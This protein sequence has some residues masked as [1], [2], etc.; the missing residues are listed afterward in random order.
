[1]ECDNKKCDNYI[2]GKNFFFR[3]AINSIVM[4]VNLCKSCYKEA[5]KNI[6]NVPNILPSNYIHA[7]FLDRGSKYGI[8]SI[9]G[10]NND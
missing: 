10:G 7:A 3:F 1:M 4:G 6:P 8:T 9:I 5:C 2:N